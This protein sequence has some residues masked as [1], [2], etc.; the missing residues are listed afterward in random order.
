MTTPCCSTH[1]GSGAWRRRD[2]AIL[3]DDP[4]ARETGGPPRRPGL[5]PDD[6]LDR[7]RTFFGSDEAGAR[8]RMADFQVPPG[9]TAATLRWYAE[10]ARR[11]LADPR[12]ATS[13]AVVVQTLRLQLVARALA[14]LALDGEYE[15]GGSDAVR[16]LQRSLNEVLEARLDVDGRL[17]P[18][19][20][21]AIRT[22]QQLAGLGVDGIPG[23]TTDAALR[24]AAAPSCTNH[25]QPEVILD[26]FGF[27]AVT[28]PRAHRTTILHV[29]RCLLAS[30]RGPRPM[31]TV[32]VVGHTDAEGS[33]AYNLDLG[34]RRAQEA[35]RL[36]RETMEAIRPGSSGSIAV[37]AESRG[38]FDMASSSDP[39]RNRRVVIR[40][41]HCT[42]AGFFREYDLMS[43]PSPRFGLAANERM[44]Q[45]QREERARMVDAVA[46]ELL[47][48]RNRRAAAARAGTIPA[49]E[50]VAAALLPAVDTLSD[51]QIALFRG[52]FPGGTSGI[53][54]GHLGECFERFANGELRDPVK[55]AGTE[56]FG[57]PEGG[58]FFLFA[59]FAF[60]CIESG[61]ATHVWQ[62]VLRPFVLAQEIF[63]HV[64]RTDPKAPAPPVAAP[65]P[66]LGAATRGLDSGFSFRSFNPL[67]RSDDA[68]KAALRAKY[69]PMDLPALRVAARDNLLRAQRMP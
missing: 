17:G 32:R 40:L 57:E 31:T 8:R 52:C 12:K 55:G 6:Q 29:V 4:S 11:A 47:R 36:V 68:R 24:A 27:D 5:P 37:V 66:A 63:M 58:F 46:K 25:R 1:T 60:L 23:P 33:D 2:T 59:E 44:S 26:G 45:P 14:T 39:A 48:R 3:L 22:F 64:Y 10:V 50:P 19:T 13:K 62:P 49:P 15:T 9:L 30:L 67:A 54:L 38:E 65:L 43:S 41:P 16:A 56:G 21:A 42:C 35:A 7:L 51:A 34:R 69:A 18:A 53:D 61:L 20:T 28:V